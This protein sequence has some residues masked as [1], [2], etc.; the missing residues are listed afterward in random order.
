MIRQLNNFIKEHWFL[1]CVIGAIT[2]FFYD[3]YRDEISD[4][5]EMEK[6]KSTDKKIQNDISKKITNSKNFIIDNDT[7]IISTVNSK[8]INKSDLEVNLKTIINTNHKAFSL[9]VDKYELAE[10]SLDSK[11]QKALLLSFETYYTEFKKQYKIV[12]VDNI[13][14][15]VC[16]S[17]DGVKVIYGTK[18]Y[19]ENI[20]ITYFSTNDNSYK[21]KIFINGKTL[22][23][24]EDYALLRGYVIKDGIEKYFNEL[25]GKIQ[26]RTKTFKE[27]GSIYRTSSITI[28][29]N[30]FFEENNLK[31]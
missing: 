24:N 8:K 4:K 30:N 20:S 9:S 15:D 17:A 5:K 7:A 13:N 29:Y 31:L 21:T 10:Y 11:A 26:L 22:L 28:Q 19:G 14:I 1:F 3:Y 25:K 12:N 27:V 2:A 16:G 23:T 6:L 18:Y